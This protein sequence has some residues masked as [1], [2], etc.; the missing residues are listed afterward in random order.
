MTFMTISMGGF[1]SLRLLSLFPPI[2]A[3]EREKREREL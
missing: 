3:A 2:G 1:L